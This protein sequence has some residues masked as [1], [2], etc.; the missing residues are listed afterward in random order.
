MPLRFKIST[1]VLL[2]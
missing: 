1:P 2:R